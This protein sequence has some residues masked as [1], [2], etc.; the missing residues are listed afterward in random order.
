M[1]FNDL[2][3]DLNSMIQQLGTQISYTIDEVTDSFYGIVSIEDYE[4]ED[5]YGDGINQPDMKKLTIVCTSAAA[6]KASQ[7]ET[8]SF[9]H[10]DENFVGGTFVIAE[11]LRPGDGTAILILEEA[12]E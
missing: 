8:I 7:A 4:F 12:E 5:S 3:N 6:A 1:D 11:I 9:E 10:A 2:A